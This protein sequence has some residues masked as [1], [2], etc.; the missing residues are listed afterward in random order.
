MGQTGR[1]RKQTKQENKLRLSYNCINQAYSMKCILLAP[2]LLLLALQLPTA[3]ASCPGCPEET[4]VNQEIVDSP[5]R[6][7]REEWGDCAR[8]MSSGWKTSAL[9]WWLAC[10]TSS[11]WSWSITR[12]TQAPVRWLPAALRPATWWCMTYPGRNRRQWNGTRWTVLE[13]HSKI[14]IFNIHMILHQI[15]L[16]HIISYI[17]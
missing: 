4:E 6:S 1:E 12:K 13:I 7:W 17:L 3:P 2:C 14:S 10:C 5:C 11:T 15:I 8:R 16:Y 9:R